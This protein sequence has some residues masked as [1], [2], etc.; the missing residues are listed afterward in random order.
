MPSHI[1]PLY[2]CTLSVF[3]NN[4]KFLRRDFF[5]GKDY[6]IY[7]FFFV[8]KKGD[9][10][11]APMTLLKFPLKSQNSPR[12]QPKSSP[13]F[14]GNVFIFVLDVSHGSVIELPFLSPY[15]MFFLKQTQKRLPKFFKKKKRSIDRPLNY[16]FENSSIRFRMSFSSLVVNLGNPLRPI[17]RTEQIYP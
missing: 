14:A 13:L 12:P 11:T 1:S 15:V 4:T 8:K 3:A 5:R 10:A 16:S 7:S 6:F 9:L 17:A 2:K